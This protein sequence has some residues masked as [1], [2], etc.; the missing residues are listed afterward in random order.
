[1]AGIAGKQK[2]K[3][4]GLARL[5]DG[6][7]IGNGASDDWSTGDD[8]EAY[9]GLQMQRS[10]KKLI[11]HSLTGNVTLSDPA[12]NPEAGP[13]P[14][15]LR[16]V[17]QMAEPSWHDKAAGLNRAV[18]AVGDAEAPLALGMGLATAPIATIRGLAAYSALQ[19]GGDALSNKLGVDP[20]YGRAAIGMAG[21]VP[22]GRFS[23]EDLSTFVQRFEEPG[24]PRAQFSKPHGIYT[25]P[26]DVESPH[27]D[28]GGD[29]YLWRKNPDANVLSL[30]GGDR[31]IAIRSGAIDAGAGVYAARHLLGQGEFDRIKSMSRGDLAREMAN[32][33]PDVDWDRYYDKQ[34]VIE[35]IGGVLARQHGYDAI[36]VKDP[37]DRRWDEF[38][39]LTP[40]SM[41][42]VDK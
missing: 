7:F 24:V 37:H 5:A 10:A 31:S 35:G 39:G 41:T 6:G 33:Y 40:Q 28:L 15:F 27:A 16:G 9:A 34:D 1:M 3:K 17:Y 14:E 26:A 8:P 29:Q 13:G 32:K 23:P 2:R 25:T 30:Q 12:L 22:H 42:P 18:G 19:G 20:E 21:L 11:P 36:E 4:R 38:V